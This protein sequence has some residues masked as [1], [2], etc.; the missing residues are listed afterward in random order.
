MARQ[1]VPDAAALAPI[2]LICGNGTLPGAVVERLRA[3]GRKTYVVAIRGEAE[4]GLR[5]VADVELGFGQIGRLFKGLGKAGCQELILIGG[6]VKRPD[7]TSIL[8]DP[9][10]LW[11]LPRIIKAMAGGDDSLLG[12]VIG[13]FESEGFQVVGLHDVAPDLLAGSGALGR[14]TPDANGLRD[15]TLALE[16]ARRLGDLD[17]GQGAVAVAGRVIALEGA[18]GT[19]AMLRRCADLRANGRIR[20]TTPGGVLVKTVKPGQDLRVDLPAIGPKTIALA[21]SAGLAGIAVQAQGALIA[22]EA[23]TLQAADDAGLFVFG[24][25]ADPRDMTSEL[26]P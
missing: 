20:A 23:Q 24:F 11:R 12:K 16:A 18:E 13:I 5:Q 17:I 4:D 21:K 7:F 14:H 8:G 25:S 6:I 26:Q 10:T 1:D 22:E 9:G 2:G 15:M 3:A 19:D